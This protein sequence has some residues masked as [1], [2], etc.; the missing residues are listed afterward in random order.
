[1]VTGEPAARPVVMV[2]DD[3]PELRTLLGLSL[4]HI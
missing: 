2:V 1:M 3:E 4:I